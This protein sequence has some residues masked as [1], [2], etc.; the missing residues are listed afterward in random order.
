VSPALPIPLD[1]ERGR[2]LA[3]EWVVAWNSHDLDTIMALYAPD[4]VFQTPTIID[5]LGIPDGTVRGADALREHFS[6][7][8]ERLPDL[9]FDL[10]GVYAGVR[11]LAMTYRWAD[12][13]PV[14]E[15][16]EYD[17]QG[18]IA[19]VQALYRGLSW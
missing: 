19:R 11:S 7:G 5:T 1:S 4:V 16:H 17:E 3:E 15:L 18:L 2:E 8:L 13:T 12:G 14:C 6:R 10:D 9:R